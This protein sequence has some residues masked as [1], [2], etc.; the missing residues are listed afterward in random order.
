L[1]QRGACI[2]GMHLEYPYD[3]EYTANQYELELR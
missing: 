3:L 1:F 2:V